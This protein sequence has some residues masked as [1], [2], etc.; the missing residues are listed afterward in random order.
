M[1]KKIII[2]ALLV[3]LTGVVSAGG[4][5]G[6]AYTLTMSP[7]P[8]TVVTMNPTDTFALQGC[9]AYSGSPCLLGG[10]IY[11]EFWNGTW[12]NVTTTSNLSASEENPQFEEGSNCYYLSTYWTITANDAWNRNYSVR[13]YSAQGGFTGNMTVNVTPPVADAC[14]TLTANKNLSS[15][16]TTSG[17]CMTIGA[18]NVVLDCKNHTI[19]YGSS[20]GSSSTLVYGI[21]NNG[22]NGTTIKNCIIASGDF[23]LDD[24]GGDVLGG[25]GI[26]F[27]NA[28]NSTITNNS[29]CVQGTV[30]LTNTNF[31]F[32]GGAYNLTMTNNTA[33]IGCGAQVVYNNGYDLELGDTYNSTIKNFT[34]KTTAGNSYSRGIYLHDVIRNVTI[35]DSNIT[36]LN[37]G[38]AIY[39]TGTIHNLTINS[40]TIRLQPASK[41]IYLSGG[42]DVFVSRINL[43]SGDNCVTIASTTRA[44][45]GNSSFVC[46]SSDISASN[47]VN[48]TYFRNVTLNKSQI[49]TATSSNITIQWYGRVNVTNSAGAG[50]TATVN[51]TQNTTLANGTF[52]GYQALTSWFL[53]NDTTFDSVANVTFNKHTIV[54]NLTG[55]T[56]NVTFFNWTGRDYTA[57]ITLYSTSTD[58]CTYAGSG[59]WIIQTADL[60]SITTSQYL[61]TNTLTFNG[62][63]GYTN[64]GSLTIALINITAKTFFFNISGT[65]T[66]D[67]RNGAT[68]LNGTMNG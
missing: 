51:D 68:W 30:S 6:C 44:L 11:A 28:R 65:A 67:G 61:G 18:N 56:T 25:K 27:T 32:S 45:F 12:K 66:I 53:V 34:A 55:Y 62:T 49:S 60:C 17:T 24:G 54:T 63:T 40:S 47:Y 22:Y 42:N 41:G 14:G 46:T 13:L 36:F 16:V 50:L 57:N 52:Y 59:N 9:I 15:D 5:G 39:A 29:I 3:M 33:T 1:D 10:A 20:G 7:S 64:L 26:Y 4:G 19:T 23:S 35:T 8:G 2:L 37:D 38:D 31:E 43:T 48:N 58:S 21:R